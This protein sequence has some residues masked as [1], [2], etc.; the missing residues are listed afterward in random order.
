[1]KISELIQATNAKVFGDYDEDLIN[2]VMSA[3][4]K[5]SKCMDELRV[6]DAIDEV[7]NIFRRCNKYIDETTPWILAK[8]E[9]KDRLK[10]VIYNLLESIRICAVYLNPFITITS[11]KIFE[12][13]NTDVKGIEST[14]EFGGLV[15]GT[16]LNEPVHLFDRIEEDYG[17]MSFDGYFIFERYN[18]VLY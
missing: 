2:T 17:R 12:Q 4:D 3:K 6:A 1:M 11:D 9:N 7:F 13:L 14:E 18:F 5:V 16:V 10:K 15:P 8:E